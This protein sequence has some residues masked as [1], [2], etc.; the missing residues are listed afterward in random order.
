MIMPTMTPTLRPLT[1]RRRLAAASRL[2][3]ALGL[4]LLAVAGPSGPAAAQLFG[5][6]PPRLTL[7]SETLTAS[8]GVRNS[9]PDT[10]RFA[11]SWTYREMTEQGELL[12]AEMPSL[13]AADLVRF[14]P[15]VFSVPPNTTQRVRFA[16]RPGGN[17]PD[18]EYRG[19]LVVTPVAVGEGR[20]GAGAGEG[21]SMDLGTRV[22][23]SVPVIAR[24]GPG[25]V[26]TT[27]DW[28]RLETVEGDEDEPPRQEVVAY[29]ARTGAFSSIG[30]IYLQDLAGDLA[31][32][33]GVAVYHELPGRIIRVPLAR[34]PSGPMVLLYRAQT[35]DPTQEGEVLS[36]IQ[37][38]Q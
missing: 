37:V 34:E 21:A 14:A 32:S 27:F 24:V 25:D 26:S 16:L 10:I 17:V 19:H 31:V 9:S 13:S 4:M 23:Y 33:R 2:A 29:L 12:E 18:G 15:R 11:L 30:D 36:R 28:A 38:A 5:V 20:Q 7:D 22:I 3:A 35:E 1:I 6:A 8:L